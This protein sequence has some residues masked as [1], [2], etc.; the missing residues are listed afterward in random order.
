VGPHT[1]DGVR[2]EVRGEPGQDHVFY[3][4]SPGKHV[5]DSVQHI[6]PGSRGIRLS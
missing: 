2:V 3:P 4:I 1:I 6:I 5:I